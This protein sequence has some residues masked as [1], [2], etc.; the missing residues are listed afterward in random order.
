MG[1]TYYKIWIH[2]IWSTK[3][4]QKL[5]IKELRNK[6]FEHIKEKAKSEGFYMD[7]INGISDHLHCLISIN[8]KYSI[9]EAANKLKGESSH[10]IN[11]EKLLKLHFAWQNGFSAFSVSESQLEKVRKYIL[12]Q[13]EHHKKMSFEEELKKIL[14]LHKIEEDYGEKTKI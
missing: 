11:S 4:R 5:M 3:D 6:I 7:S 1:Q 8:P 9:S 10:W 13:E 14:K 2:L 12:N